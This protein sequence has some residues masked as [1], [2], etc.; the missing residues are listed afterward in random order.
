MLNCSVREEISDCREV[1]DCVKGNEVP[2][3][4]LGVMIRLVGRGVSK[5]S[6]RERFEELRL[7]P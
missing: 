1:P 2:D 5:S 3:S 7:L 4:L 6:L